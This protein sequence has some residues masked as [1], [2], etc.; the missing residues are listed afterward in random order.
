MLYWGS[1]LPVCP[2]FGRSNHAKILVPCC[3]LEAVASPLV[4]VRSERGEISGHGNSGEFF[5]LLGLTWTDLRTHPDGRGRRS[6]RY[7]ILF[8]RLWRCPERKWRCLALSE[9][10]WGQ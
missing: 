10:W 5:T 2:V 1:D 6:L 3:S 9:Y 4:S 7:L 8:D